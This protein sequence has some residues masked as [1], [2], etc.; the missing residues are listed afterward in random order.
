M[1][2]TI[3][4][5]NEQIML[6]TNPQIKSTLT[7]VVDV[8]KLSLYSRTANK[9]RVID[10]GK[11]S[12]YKFLQT[13]YAKRQIGKHF[14]VLE[15]IIEGEVVEIRNYTVEDNKIGS[16][17]ICYSY[18]NNSWLQVSDTI[19]TKVDLHYELI[20]INKDRDNLL[21]NNQSGAILSEFTGLNITCH[22]YI[23]SSIKSDNAILK[24]MCI[25]K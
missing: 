17:V 12:R 5:I 7:K 18:Y 14:Y 11:P 19:I 2:R 16:Q 21:G 9:Q 6:T 22:Y 13:I 20:N 8:L 3:G 24:I 1:K 15:T 10:K 23:P 4:S 25:K